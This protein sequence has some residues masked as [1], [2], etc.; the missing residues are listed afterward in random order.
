[1][2]R[3]PLAPLPWPVVHVPGA[4]SVGA[5]ASARMHASRMPVPPWLHLRSMAHVSVHKVM[6]TCCPVHPYA[7]PQHAH[8]PTPDHCAVRQARR[9]AASAVRVHVVRGRRRRRRRPPRPLGAARRRAAVAAELGRVHR[10]LVPSSR[11]R[12]PPSAC[13]QQRRPPPRVSR[14]RPSEPA[15]PQLGARRQPR[16]CARFC[17]SM[18]WISRSTFLWPTMTWC[19]GGAVSLSGTYSVGRATLTLT[20][21]AAVPCDDVHGPSP[22]P[23]SREDR[24]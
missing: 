10:P 11:L 2:P 6:Y 21:P 13:V 12:P 8:P 3:P 4:A 7:R 14:R 9:H 22:R 15:R 20:G 17:C 18:P 5:A 19:G 16:T 1:M 24:R 23:P